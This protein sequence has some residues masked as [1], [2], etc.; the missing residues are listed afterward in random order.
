MSDPK[1]IGSGRSKPA[2][3]EPAVTGWAG[4]E[5]VTRSTR[6]ALPPLP[7]LPE[8]DEELFVLYATTDSDRALIAI[9]NRYRPK[10]LR[11][12]SR[13]SV[14]ASRAEDLTQ[15]VFI[16][17]IRNKHSY[18]PSQ[19]FS[20]WS[21]TI[22]ERIAMNAARSAQRSRVSSFSDLGFEDDG[23]DEWELDPPDRERLPDD[24]AALSEARGILDTAL[25]EIEPRYREPLVLHF[26]GE[27]T[28]TEAARV[29][30]IPVGTA[31]SRTNHAIHDLREVLARRGYAAAFR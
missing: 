8:S 11:Y 14:T 4:G 28:H 9:V 30:G 23:D 18:D 24:A 26:L 25:A 21:K 20:T 1:Q 3:G 7:P 27:L 6:P 10:I 22:T 16:R 13:N 29:L 15:E 5:T 12:F 19:R 17:I 2:G 31:K